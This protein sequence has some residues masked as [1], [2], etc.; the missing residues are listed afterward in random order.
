MGHLEEHS[1]RLFLHVATPQ[2]YD[3]IARQTPPI[4]RWV[5]GF[6]RL[7]VEFRRPVAGHVDLRLERGRVLLARVQAGAPERLGV[8]RLPTELLKGCEYGEGGL[9]YVENNVF[10]TLRARPLEDARLE[11]DTD[12][13]QIVGEFDRYVSSMQLEIA[14][15]HP[16][17]AHIPWR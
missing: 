2:L 11:W 17:F 13:L 7:V 15:L 16:T 5:G 6:V 3:G 4:R 8:K 12:A 14:Y 9:G 10:P 1:N